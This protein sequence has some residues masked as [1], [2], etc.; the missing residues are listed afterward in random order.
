MASDGNLIKASFSNAA[1][2]AK[3]SVQ[4][5]SKDYQRSIDISKS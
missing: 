1:L 5:M 4:D 2:A 3:S